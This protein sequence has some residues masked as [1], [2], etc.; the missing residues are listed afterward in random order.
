MAKDIVSLESITVPETAA[1]LMASGRRTRVLVVNVG[2]ASATGQLS[3]VDAQGAVVAGGQNSITLGTA[4]NVADPFRS[5]GVVFGAPNGLS[6]F[7]ATG[8]TTYQRFN[9]SSSGPGSVAN[10]TASA[11]SMPTGN[12]EGC[13]LIE[14]W[15]GTLVLSGLRSDPQNWFM[16]RVNAVTDFDY[17][18]TSASPTQAVAGNTAPAGLVGDVVNAMV[19]WDQQ[20]VFGCDHGVYVL[21]GHPADG[22][23]IT[24]VLDGVGMAFGRP[25]CKSPDGTLFFYSVDGDAYA[26]PKGG[27]PTLLSEALGDE[28]ERDLSTHHARMVWDTRTRGLYLFLT[29]NTAKAEATHWFW[30]ERTGGWF[31]FSFENPLWNPKAVCVVDG[32]DPADRH[33][34]LSAWDGFVHTFDPTADRDNG[35][36]AIASE[37]WL[38]P[39]LT[40]TADEME[41]KELVAVLAEDSDDVTATVHVGHTP[42][43]ARASAAATE[44]V[45]WVAGRNAATP[46]R[47]RAHALFVRIT[48]EGKWAFE[49]LRA[50]VARGGKVR[51]RSR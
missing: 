39:V 43:E 47:R 37:A 15:R 13:R 12:G 26:W 49:S 48:S 33:V 3:E 19:P 45:T 41:V 10:W 44:P 42:E 31:P 20:L 16:P 40:Q 25:W 5:T 7:Y 30:E 6:M 1:D 8:S 17:A 38:G 34:L 28:L 27:R 50:T 21:D 4:F 18:P 2:E 14:A 36:K 29:P 24:Q 11:G 22:G 51:G 46:V 9:L 35:S 32:D 23:R